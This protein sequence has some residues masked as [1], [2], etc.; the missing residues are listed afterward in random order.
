MANVIQR[1][2]R[3]GGNAELGSEQIYEFDMFKEK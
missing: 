1:S 3:R 2:E